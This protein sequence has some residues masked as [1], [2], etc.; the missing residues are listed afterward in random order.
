[1]R[2]CNHRLDAAAV[3]RV[4]AH[5]RRLSNKRLRRKLRPI[6]TTVKTSANRTFC[7]SDACNPRTGK[8]TTCVATARRSPT[9]FATASMSDISRD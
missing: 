9:P 2:T 8:T 1:L 3:L 5:R 7:P 6:G 4:N